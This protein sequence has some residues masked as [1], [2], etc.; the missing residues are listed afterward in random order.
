MV[1]T[2]LLV[3]AVTS[4]AKADQKTADGAWTLV[5]EHA[6]GVKAAK[7]WIRPV[8]GQALV[9]DL[10]RLRALLAGAP[11]EDTAESRTRPLILELPDPNG[12][13][14]LFSVVES[15]V[16]EPG[17]AAQFPEI[18]TY[19]GQGVSDP[20]ATLRA[21]V[22]L[23]GFHAQVLTAEGAG[24]WYIDPFSAMDTAH[25]TSYF[26]RALTP[27]D[28]WSCGT[29]PAVVATQLRGT[30]GM[31]STGGT[32]RNY[33][34][35]CACTGE[36]AAFHGGTVALAQS[37][38]VSAVNRVTGVYEVE[39]CIRLTLVANNTSI[40]YTNSAT[41][42]YTNN[43]GSTMLGQNQNNLTTV[44][45]SANYDIGHVFST[46]GGGIAGLGVVCSSGNKARGV[47]GSSSPTGDAFWIDY[48]AHEMGHQFGANHNFQG[49]TSSCGGGN[50]NGSTADEPGSGSTI[51]GYAG[52]CGADDLQ[53]HSDAYFN[54]ISYE[55]IE[56]YVAGTTCATTTATSNLPP[57][58]SATGGFTIPKGTPF[59]LTATGSDPDGDAI[60]Y[61]WEDR[62]FGGATGTTL[63]TADNG[64]MPLFR[65]YTATSSPTRF[66][67]RLSSVLA[68]TSSNQEKLPAVAR[69]SFRFRVTVRDNR[70]AG[71]GVNNADV[72]L[73]V[74]STAGPF[75]VTSQSTAVS[76]TTG[77]SQTV[78]WNVAGTTAN[79]VNCA[80]VSVLLSTDGGNTFP[81]TLVA[82][83]PNNGSVSF[84][85]PNN[86]TTSGRVKVQSIGNVF[87][88]VNAGTISVLTGGCAGAS[89]TTQPLSQTACAGGNANLTLLA[90]GSTPLT[91]DWRKGGTSLGAPNAAT[92]ALN[93][94]TTADAGN[95]DCVVT[96]A[97]GTATSNTVVLTVNTPVSISSSSGS[98]ARCPG[99]SASF[100]VTATGVP[101]PTYQW[102]KG[103]VNIGGAN[104]NTYTISSVSSGDTG[105][106]DCVVTNSCGSI[107]STAAT[108]SVQSGVNFTAQPASQT[109]CDGEPVSMSVGVSGGGP[110]IYQWRRNSD[111]IPG[112]VATIYSINPASDV[113]A[114]T[115]DCVVTGGCGSATSNAAV[116]TV[117]VFPTITSQPSAAARCLG[118]SASFTVGATGAGPLT[119]QWRRGGTDIG[120]ATGP[121]YTIDAVGPSDATVYDCVVTGACG[122]TISSGAMLT[123]ATPVSIAG[124]PT[125]LDR[126][127]GTAAAFT[128]SATGEPSPSFQWRKGG[129]IL[130]GATSATLTISAVSSGDAGSYDCVVT[131]TCGSMTSAAAT[132]NVQDSV[133]ISTQ[134]T[135]IST[136]QNAPA[137][138]TV[139]AGGAP[140]IAYQWR[141]DT[142]PIEGATSNTYSITAAAS[143]DA[144][145]Y[146]C[147]VSNP[148][149]SVTSDAAA[150]TLST[151]PT[152]SVQPAAASGCTGGEVMISLTATSTPAPTYQWRKAS[153][154][155][156]GA[157]SSSLTLSG[158]SAADVA[159]YDCV[160]TND[161][162]SVTS[163]PAT[164]T[165]VDGPTITQHPVA[166]EVCVGSNTGFSVVAAAATSYQWQRD[167][168]PLGDGP[169][170][171]GSTIGGAT[172]AS[173]T[174]TGVTSADVGGYT[175]VLTASCG[176]ATS[177][178]AALTIAPGPT[179]TQQPSAQG[180]CVG[181][182]VELS[183][184]VTGGSPLGYQWRKGGT[185]IQDATSAT[186]SFV[187]LQTGNAGSY[188]CVVTDP[189]GSATSDSVTVTV[190]LPDYNCSGTVS[191]QDIFDFLAGYFSNESRA[192]VNHSGVVGVQDI[193]DFLAAY[194]AGC[195]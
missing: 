95:Y 16:M 139:V 97:C 92:L 78:T 158:L 36:Y 157:A 165:V 194:F 99:T 44:I 64:V 100:S 54:F 175:C 166:V 45:G 69:A 113:D 168:S 174:I 77:T 3:V 14:Q 169:A 189:C 84:T 115:Y 8:A 25:Y 70:A 43:S 48:V 17:L 42:P 108:L 124:Q 138:F 181:A 141:K 50:R 106:Y 127:T 39:L 18:K 87:Y 33:R 47:T 63:A 82:S 148:C 163:D 107:T 191:V 187:T 24:S 137:A 61:C 182:T 161:C 152:I 29:E 10:T 55:E 31:I 46:G 94:V 186:L 178:A 112:A 171:S 101:T 118:Q 154:P 156:S 135:A 22:T 89:I 23:E 120:G 81:I 20:H 56:N 12:R 128:V 105:S 162:G 159:S 75:T 177:N 123:I 190:C 134:P 9:G 142:S 188:D 126:C 119:F 133:T 155:I 5:P 79:G 193:F 76:W 37:A 136:C 150:L 125:A 121:T 170:P 11:L 153:A 116:L 96:N 143:G 74:N 67:P 132:L 57:T 172:T 88:A 122:T 109:I 114:G 32:R 4:T 110:F 167:G 98:I 66:F 176:T 146:D 35:A 179:I 104:L 180:G 58:V 93:G 71:G 111:P 90:G 91:Y 184:Q 192:D 65:S 173:L 183:I 185:P 140:P 49:T 117:R 60:T 68:G 149:G 86:T 7:E 131:N 1:L 103:S 40:V 129:T 28:G 38:I 85:V 27:K 53:A 130:D 21:D 83:T 6:P 26:R 164:V 51:M 73:A 160:V 30:I 195:P 145:S 62:N 52:I 13:L 15:P 147:V 72:T 144:G 80:N 102:R 2:V 34:L 151:S 19:V 59:V 41:D